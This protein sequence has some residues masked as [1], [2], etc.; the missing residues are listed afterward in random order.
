MGAPVNWWTYFTED[1]A[2]AF[3][4]VR[5]KHKE[6]QERDVIR[7]V[8]WCRLPNGRTRWLCRA[9]P[10]PRPLYDLPDFLVSTSRLVVVVEGE[11]C[12][13]AAARVFPD[14]IVTTW[15]GGSKAWAKTDWRPLTGREI[16][17]VSDADEPG[18]IAMRE[19]ASHLAPMG[20]TVRL[21]LP[22]GDDGYDIADAV[23]QQGLEGRRDRIE[24]QA[25][26]WKPEATDPPKEAETN[27][28]PIAGEATNSPDA[29]EAPDTAD[30][31]ENKY[32]S[33]VGRLLRW[34]DFWQGEPSGSGRFVSVHLFLGGRLADVDCRG[35]SRGRERWPGR[36]PS[37]SVERG[38]EASDC[39]GDS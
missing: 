22:E 39:G 14:C 33:G 2:I 21:Y 4:V 6:P 26:P 31:S 17:S 10:A 29:G 13:D 18:R 37:P 36:S 15:A 35:E 23:D 7:P 1:G 19:L 24:R 34:H 32:P 20:C 8:T 5:W 16:L 9:M 11:K 28:A 3:H 38:A 25:I 27:D 30:T 12:A